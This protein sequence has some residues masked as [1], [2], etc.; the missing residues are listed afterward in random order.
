MQTHTASRRPLLNNS[1]SHTFIHI[2]YI[3]N[4]KYIHT[5]PPVSFAHLRRP[6]ISLVTSAPLST[7]ALSFQTFGNAKIKN[8]H[9]PLATSISPDEAC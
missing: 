3:L 6:R 1:H 5:A 2:R 7:E 4:F 8:R 9:N